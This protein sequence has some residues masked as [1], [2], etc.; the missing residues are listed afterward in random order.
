MP[1]S[2]R[3]PGQPWVKPLSRQIG[4]KSFLFYN[5]PAQVTFLSFS[6]AAFGLKWEKIRKTKWLFVWRGWFQWHSSGS[7]SLPAGCDVGVLGAHICQQMKPEILNSPD[8]MVLTGFALDTWLL[9]FNSNYSIWYNDESL[10]Q[11]LLFDVDC[12]RP[13]A[14][15]SRPFLQPWK[16]GTLAVSH[17]WASR[18]GGGRAGRGTQAVWPDLHPTTS[19]DSRKLQEKMCACGT[20][21]WSS[22]REISPSGKTKWGRW[23]MKLYSLTPNLTW[24]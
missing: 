15:L 24:G 6:S 22:S 23:N 4:L 9:G 14:S 18:L 17:R 20:D 2:L 19:Q 8:V 3:L 11:L 5:V 1:Q 12:F 21:T 16:E 10:V 7:V 13:R